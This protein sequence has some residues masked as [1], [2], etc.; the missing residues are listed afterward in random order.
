M[1]SR[2]EFGAGGGALRLT[3]LVVRSGKESLE[4]GPHLLLWSE[5][6]PYF[7]VIDEET[8]LINKLEGDAS[9]LF[10]TVQSVSGGGVVATI[11]TRSKRDLIGWLTS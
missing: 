4:A 10:E 2:V 6:F 5:T 8:G 1:I 7:A 11:L 3:P 9:Y